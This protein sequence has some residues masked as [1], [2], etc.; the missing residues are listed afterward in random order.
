MPPQ[1]MHEQER[2]AEVPSSE[3]VMAF[4]EARMGDKEARET[5]RIVDEEGLKKLVIEVRGEKN[6]EV[7]EYTFDRKAAAGSKSGSLKSSISVAFYE[8]DMPVG[9]S[10]LADYENGEW[11]NQE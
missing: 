4:L 9:G 7:T 5:K 8:D 1:E 2:S 6:G 11:V 10:V 3:E